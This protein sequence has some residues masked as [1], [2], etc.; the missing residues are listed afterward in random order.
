MKLRNVVK[1]F[2]GNDYL[3][4]QRDGGIWGIDGL[5]VIA[6][7]L[8]GSCHAPLCE[9][10]DLEVLRISVADDNRVYNLRVSGLVPLDGDSNEA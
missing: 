7:N 9:L 10:L 3:N 2:D 5:L 4:L 1:M 8:Q 6:G